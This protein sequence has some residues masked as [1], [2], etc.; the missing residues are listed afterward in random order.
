MKCFAKE[1][2][3]CVTQNEIWVWVVNVVFH[4][5]MLITIAEKYFFKKKFSSNFNF[6]NEKFENNYQKFVKK[7]Q[8]KSWKLNVKNLINSLNETQYQELCFALRKSNM[9]IWVYMVFIAPLTH[10]NS[11]LFHDKTMEH[12]NIN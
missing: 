11:I 5:D 4:S 3:D 1:K 8:L 10:L 2:Y 9:N 6:G 7:T 12:L